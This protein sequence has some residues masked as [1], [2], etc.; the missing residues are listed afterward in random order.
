MRRMISAVFSNAV[1]FHFGKAPEQGENKSAFQQN[2]SQSKKIFGDCNNSPLY[3]VQI[4]TKLEHLQNTKVPSLR[5]AME[6]LLFY[7][8]AMFIDHVVWA[9][10]GVVHYA[11]SDTRP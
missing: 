4:V 10:N 7:S 8:Y 1:F 3:L 6:P 11:D 5:G 9:C 2:T